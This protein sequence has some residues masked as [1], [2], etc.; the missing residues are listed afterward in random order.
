MNNKPIIYQLLPRLFTNYNANCVPSGTI[1]QNGSGKL[2]TINPS[3]L[4]SI[5]DMGITH[6]WLTG[7]IEH[8]HCSDYTAYG[9]KRDNPH[10]VKGQ[11]GSPYAISD[12]YD[13]DPDIAVDPRARMKEFE[14]TVERIHAAG[15]KVIIDFVP[16]HVA[17]R[18]RSDAKPAD[19]PHDFGVDDYVNMFFAPSNNFYYI[20]GHAF[21]PTVDMGTGPDAYREFPAKASGN[22]CFTASPGQYDWYETVKLNY[23]IDPANGWRHFSPIPSTWHKMLH[24]LHYWADKGIDGFRCDMAFMVPLEFWQWAIPQIKEKHPHIIFIAEIYDVNLYR[25]FI[26]IGGFDY[27]YDK[28]G[29]Y[30]TLRDIVTNSRPAADITHAWQKIDGHQHNMLYFLENHDE[31]RFASQQ[32]AGD[33]RK[34]MA[35]MAVSALLGPGAV[36]LYAGQELGE[37]GADAEGYSGADGRTTIFDYWSIDTLRRWLNSGRPTTKHLTDEEKELRQSYSQLLN[38]AR[39][40]KAITD[41]AFFDVMYVN[42]AGPRFNPQKHYAFLRRHN[43]ET[44]L[45]VTN[46]DSEA[47]QVEVNLPQHAFNILS[48]PQGEFLTTNLLTGATELR[49][50]SPDVTFATEVPAHGAVVWKWADI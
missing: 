7:V 3:I 17:R 48:M 40:E 37:P 18:Y 41:G 36:M 27:L 24:I 46:F 42:P 26:E 20:P 35:P 47:A 23:G 12:Y 44:I 28:V 39:S 4:R 10:V 13:I 49:L 2:R 31:Q 16:N 25:P 14:D 11:A 22:D 5:A 21:A 34:A 45:V 43:S 1:D 29:L 32:F 33:A 19:A 50:I 38:V 9:I 15:L 8:A 6:V 30:D